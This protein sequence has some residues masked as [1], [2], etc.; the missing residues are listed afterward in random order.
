MLMSGPLAKYMLSHLVT[1]CNYQRTKFI[2]V[3]W[4]EYI[5]AANRAIIKFWA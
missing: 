5:E 3:L 2:L 1:K 4:V